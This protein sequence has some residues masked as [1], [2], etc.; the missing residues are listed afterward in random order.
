MRIKFSSI[1]LAGI[2]RNSPYHVTLYI[3]QQHPI[4]VYMTGF[5]VC[6]V[7]VLIVIRRSCYYFLDRILFYHDFHHD[8]CDYH[9]DFMA[10][11][12]ELY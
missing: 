8:S 10:I 1:Q 5:W 9:L 12:F 3:G 11:H 4:T 7:L 2:D 6:V